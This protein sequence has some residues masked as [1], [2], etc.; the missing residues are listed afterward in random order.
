MRWSGSSD[1][2]ITGGS[3][4]E[5]SSSTFCAS[6]HSLLSTAARTHAVAIPLPL[7]G[8]VSTAQV[9]VGKQIQ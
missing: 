9:A 4:E 1:A 2:F 6:H 3:G 5:A 8:R 7:S